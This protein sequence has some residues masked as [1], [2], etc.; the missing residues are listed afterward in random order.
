MGQGTHVFGLGKR[1]IQEII[2]S[3]ASRGLGNG[4][5]GM[6]DESLFFPMFQTINLTA[7]VGLCNTQSI[8]NY[9]TFN[10]FTLNLTACLI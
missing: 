8:L 2:L 7:G 5:T 9:K 4:G 3:R 6:G 1:E 10:F